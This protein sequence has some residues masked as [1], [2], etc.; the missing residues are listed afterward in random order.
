MKDFLM[1]DG[2]KVLIREAVPADAQNIIDFYN[3]VGG[4]TDFLSFG[5][6]EFTRNAGEYETY[7]EN[8]AAE[9]N[10]IMLLATIGDAIISIATINSSQKARTKHDGMLE[11]VISQTHTGM[12]LG[13]RMMTELIEWAKHNRIT[14]RISLV[15]REDNHRAIALY[16]KLGFEVEGLIRND[17]YFNGVYY[18]TV[19][20]GLL[21]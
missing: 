9:E 20:M 14:R 18:S 2:N 6:N 4:E 7:I 15:T 12:G 13:E 10:S 11:I 16:K 21:F 3:V 19:V 17:T 8:V 1:K 5:G